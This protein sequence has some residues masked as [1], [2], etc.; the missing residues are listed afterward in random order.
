MHA[1]GLKRG[2]DH[3]G[4]RGCF[5]ECHS[6]SVVKTEDLARVLQGWTGR[7]VR[8]KTPLPR[9]GYG[10]KGEIELISGDDLNT[11]GEAFQRREMGVDAQRNFI[12]R[13]LGGRES[14]RTRADFHKVFSGIRAMNRRDGL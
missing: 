7:T 2:L 5:P 3:D 11:L 13:Q 4:L 14:I 10:T 6:L 1:E 8:R 9:K 12:R